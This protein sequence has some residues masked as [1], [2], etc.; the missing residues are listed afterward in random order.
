MKKYDRILIGFI[1]SEFRSDFSGRNNPISGSVQAI[2][3]VYVP[4]ILHAI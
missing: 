1:P 3:C 4:V 2:V